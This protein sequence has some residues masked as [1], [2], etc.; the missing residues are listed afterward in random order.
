MESTGVLKQ[1]EGQTTLDRRQGKAK[2][3]VQTYGTVISTDEIEEEDY[4]VLSDND[5]IV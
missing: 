4:G 1:S 3:Q 2:V 5:C